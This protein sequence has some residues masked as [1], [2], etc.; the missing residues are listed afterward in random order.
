MDNKF[1]NRLYVP[2]QDEDLNVEAI[3]P[4]EA[5]RRQAEAVNLSAPIYA[6]LEVVDSL[7]RKAEHLESEL[8]RVVLAHHMDSLKSVQTRTNDLVDA[9]VLSAAASVPINGKYRDLR[10]H[11]LKIRR[12]IARLTARKSKLE[13]RL[14]AIEYTTDR[15]DSVLNWNKF[16][17]RLEYG[18]G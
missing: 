16:I 18:R 4:A 15:L 14:K 12:R 7:L 13:R 6:E 1:W 2:I 8:T 3:N 17:G 5:Y 9:F 10:P 11:L